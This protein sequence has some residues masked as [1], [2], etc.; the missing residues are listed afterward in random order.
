MTAQPDSTPMIEVKG[1][2]K[3]F[4][5]EVHAVRHLEFAVEAGEVFGLLGPNG[6][7]KSTTIGMLTTTITPTSG[8]AW[9]AGF[10]VAV[11]PISARQVSSVVF[12]DSVLDAALT[13]RRNLELHARLWGVPPQAAAPR[14]ADSVSA[15]GLGELIDRPVSTYSGGQRRRL[16]IARALVSRPAVL[17]LDEPT[18]GLDTRIRY[19][20]LEL[21]DNLRTESQLTTLL[22]THYLDEAERLCD[23]VAIMSA[24]RIVA[25]GTPA[26]LVAGL[27]SELIEIKVPDDAERTL[28]TLRSHRIAG[29]DA[30]AVGS[31]IT[32]P[33]RDGSSREAIAAIADLGVGV[34]GITA[35]RPTLD[36]VY[37]QLT[38]DRIAA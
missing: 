8:Q 27:G 19:E 38:G 26:G 20:L 33:L 35:R 32:L 12:Q 5:G 17:F 4:A 1:L 7:G 18:V 14:I 25:L 3:T 21:I 36:D 24:G 13:G 23:R 37:L 30:F 28:A 6:A 9:L 16:E 2:D 34:G 10:D 31:T 22:T 29:D 11:D 15:F